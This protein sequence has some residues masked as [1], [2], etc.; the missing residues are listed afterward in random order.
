M[1]LS[2]TEDAVR[3]LPWQGGSPL[4]L[5]SGELEDFLCIASFSDNDVLL[6]I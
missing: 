1:V 6:F 2:H 4:V 3:I 5:M